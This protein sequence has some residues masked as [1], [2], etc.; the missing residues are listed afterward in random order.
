M[1]GAARAQASGGSGHGLDDV[2]AARRSVRRGRT[3]D[4]QRP[5]SRR[6][7]P[8]RVFARR[9]YLDVW[10]LLPTPERAAAFI[11][12]ANPGKRDAL[13]ATLLADNQKYARPLDLVLERP[14]AQRR[15]RHLL[16]GDRRPQEHHRVALRPRSRRTC[17]TTSS[18]RSCSIRPRPATP[19]DSSIGVNWRGETSAAV[20]PWMQASQNTAQVFLGV[21]LKCNSCHDS[22]VS[23]W[24]LKDAYALAA[25]FSP[26]PKLQLYRCDVALDRYAE[27]GFPLSRA[28]SRCRRRSSLAGPA[29]RGRGDLHRSA[30]SA[31]CRARWSTAS[32]S[33]CFGHGIVA[34]PDEMDG[35]PWS[36]E[37]LDWLA[38]DFV[39]HGY[40]LKHLIA[41]IVTSRAYQMPAV[42]RTGEPPAR[43]YV[44]AGPEVRRL[45]AEQ[46][47]DAI[48]AITGEWNVYP[49]PPAGG[50]DS[51]GAVHAGDWDALASMPPTAGLYGARVASGLVE[52]DP[53]AGASDPR[54][55][56]PGPRDAGIDAPGA[57]TRERR[58]PHAL[59]LARR[60]R[61]LG[62]TPTGTLSLYNRTVAGRGAKPAA[63]SRRRLEAQRL[64]LVVQENGSN[65]PRHCS[66][67]G[68]RRSSS[69]PA[70]SFHWRH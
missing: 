70:A 36:P 30:Q 55:G 26:D 43:G 13:V 57:G 32:G 53:R 33:A 41:T 12:D 6:W 46:F 66:R 2:V 54:P 45:T 58:D 42:T 40:D 67:R 24:K 31:G 61:M 17:R 34:N 56:D 15:R 25:Y 60:A 37:L 63:F 48:G 7:S 49:G 29:R 28:E 62:E 3:C 47:G 11:A 19:T 23:K 8:M 1:G 39:E 4:T 9:V 64:W 50:G 65:I 69:A 10:G 22:F 14:A 59:A 44:F 27:P 20:T 16:L 18:S 68:R 38:S 5:P 35:K 51:V 52:P 21:N